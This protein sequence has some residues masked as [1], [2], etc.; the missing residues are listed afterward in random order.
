MGYSGAG[1]VTRIRDAVSTSRDDAESMQNLAYVVNS[2]NDN[3]AGLQRTVKLQEKELAEKT[4]HGAALQ[5]NYETLSR[6]RK[7]D[8]KEFIALKTLQLEERTELETLQQLYAAE[9][10]KTLALERRLQASAAAEQ[11]LQKLQQELSEVARLRD[12]YQAEAEKQ[13]RRW[14]SWRPCDGPWRPMMATV[15]VAV[16]GVGSGVA[17]ARAEG[18][19]AMV[20]PLA[21]HRG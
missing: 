3:I 15:A 5:R 8:Q 14:K 9:Q 13:Q 19:C 12:E 11:Q 7:S 1:S 18:V 21:Y 4:E 16:V 2:A 10:A 20:Q 17:A 6:I